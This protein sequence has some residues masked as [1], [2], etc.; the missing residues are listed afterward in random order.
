MKAKLFLLAGM[1]SIILTACTSDIF[2][3]DMAA[4]RG[5]GLKV[6]VTDGKAD[7]RADYS[8]FPSTSF[9]TGDAIGVYAFDGSSYVTSNIRFVKQSDGSWLPDE[10]VPYN[11]DY[12]YYAY[13]PYRSTVYTP[14]TSGMVD[15]VDTKFASF[16]SD[17]SNYFW[18]A[19]QSTKANFT[20]SNLM[21]AKGSITDVDDDAVTVKFTMAH[22][23]GLA[24]FNGAVGSF[25][26]S[27]N[28]PYQMSSAKYFLMKP[29]TSTSFTD[30]EETYP[31]SAPAG[32]YVSKRIPTP[33]YLKFT[34]LEAGT[35]TLTIPSSVNTSYV[36]SV[37]YSVD[38]GETWVTT[39]NSSSAVTI[40]TPTVAAG[41]EVLWKGIAKSYGYSTTNN[42]NSK[43][44]S[45]CRFTIS[46][47]I[48]SLLNEDSFKNMVSLLQNYTFIHLFYNNAYLI[49]AENMKLPATTLTSGCY[50]SM[51]QGCTSLTTT[52][53]LPATTLANDCYRDMFYGCTSLT[54]APELPATT[55]RGSCYY[56]MFQGCTNLT[57]APELP[58]TKL[59]QSCYYGMFQV[60]TSLTSAPELPA[61]TLASSCYQSM[62]SGCTSLSTAPVLP[63]TT[64]A[65]DCYSGM[66]S[67]CTG[68]NSAPEL[69]A[70]TLQSYC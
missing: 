10:E 52:P 48:M 16:I 1:V 27:G 31:L 59:A 8:G 46:G 19:D 32:E 29:D 47:N 63:A 62:F 67:G 4:R 2:M 50:Q 66:F 42:Y 41:G 58:A 23:R 49:S 24:V 70:T 5:S 21:I 57:S 35:F 14:S 40:T 20:Y 60:C 68:L 11:E 9:E 30:G 69:P 61:T 13:F 45:T 55:L 53:V 18:K 17:A 33:D 51:F 44:T 37:S 28:L 22:K 56:R 64:L 25:S 38:G 6:E 54:S 34:A 26:F 12:S 36:T 15:A 43:F 39:P 3:E 65:N 7:T